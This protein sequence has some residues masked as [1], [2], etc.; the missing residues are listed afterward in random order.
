MKISIIT[1]VKNDKINLLKS[2]RSVLSQ[3]QKI[4]EYI[5]YDGMSNDGT[6]NFIKKYLKKNIKYICK[7]E[8]R[9]SVV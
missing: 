4:F 5:I 7:K 2:L 8:D 1:V 3:N 6:K 9:K